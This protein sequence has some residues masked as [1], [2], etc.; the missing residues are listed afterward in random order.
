MEDSFKWHSIIAGTAVVTLGVIESV[1]LLT[2]HDGEFFST[3]VVA[4]SAL[5][6]VPIVSK[7]VQNIMSER[8]NATSSSTKDPSS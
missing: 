2:G 5:G 6:G 7:S 4:I 3:I 8:K 1:A